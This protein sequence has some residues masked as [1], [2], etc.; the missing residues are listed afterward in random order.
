MQDPG[1]ADDGREV[2]TT[3]ACC[4]PGAPSNT[5]SQMSERAT[6]RYRTVLFSNLKTVLFSLWL[7]AAVPGHLHAASQ[8]AAVRTK[9][10]TTFLGT[11]LFRI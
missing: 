1:D 11:V 7:L 3:A 2:A 9:Y 5:E 8:L 10:I 6:Y 4:C